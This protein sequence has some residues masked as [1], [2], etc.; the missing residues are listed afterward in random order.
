MAL[1][2]I[3]A[4]SCSRFVDRPKLI[5]FDASRLHLRKGTHRVS[6]LCNP[7]HTLNRYLK[8]YPCFGLQR[9]LI[10]HQSYLPKLITQSIGNLILE[11]LI[12]LGTQ[13]G[14]KLEWNSPHIGDN[15]LLAR[16]DYLHNIGWD[17]TSRARHFLAS[18]IHNIDHCCGF[19]GTQFHVL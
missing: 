17:P 16:L 19:G 5:G 3:V 14:R 2:E 12:S 11:N 6:P 4:L 18:L 8:W 10:H 13:P 1:N 9:E 7:G 15:F